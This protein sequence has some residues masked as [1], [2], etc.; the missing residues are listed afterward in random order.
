MLNHHT[1]LYKK[2]VFYDAKIIK[3]SLPLYME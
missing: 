1:D 2:A 3:D